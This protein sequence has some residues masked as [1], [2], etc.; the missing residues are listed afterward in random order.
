[1]TNEQK[2]NVVELI[3]LVIDYAVCHGEYSGRNFI[4]NE[5]RLYNA[6]LDLLEA[7]GLSEEYD[8]SRVRDPER[9]VLSPRIYSLKYERMPE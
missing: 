7:L 9:I 4:I 6:I 2:E 8:V 5:E 3:N 1:M